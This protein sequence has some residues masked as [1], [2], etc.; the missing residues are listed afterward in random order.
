MN[1]RSPEN[2]ELAAVDL[3]ELTIRLYPKFGF[4]EYIGT[5]RQLEAEGFIPDGTKWPDGY[6]DIRWEFGQF[7]F[8][9]RRARP[10]GA[11]GPRRAFFD[12]D[13]WYV[14]VDP[15][16]KS[17]SD[18]AIRN[19]TRELA[20]LLHY[21]SPQG[22]AESNRQWELIEAATNDERFQRFK[23]LL[24]GLIEP[25]RQRRGRR[26]SEVSGGDYE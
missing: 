2:R 12:V 25:P 4:V 24:P 8:W 22:I 23:T 26:S 10:E 21:N 13:N 5:R 15:K 1:N 7:E 20:R 16:N 9:M 18:I 3:G 19:K 6:T 17:Y 11:K 14:R